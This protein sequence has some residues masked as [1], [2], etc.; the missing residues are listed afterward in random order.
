MSWNGFNLLKLQG[1]EILS[2]IY[3][4]CVCVCVLKYFKYINTSKNNN[5]GPMEEYV[6]WKVETCKRVSHEEYVFHLLKVK[7]ICY[8]HK[9]QVL[10]VF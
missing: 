1:E 9:T 10:I 6:S 2:K 5:W 4:E 8:K 7:R 3:R